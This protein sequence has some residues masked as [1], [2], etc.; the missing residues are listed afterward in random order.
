MI[1]GRYPYSSNPNRRRCSLTKRNA[2]ETTAIPIPPSASRLPS[3]RFRPMGR[4]RSAITTAP[5]KLSTKSG[6][7]SERQTLQ[8]SDRD[9]VARL[10]VGQALPVERHALVDVGDQRTQPLQ[11]QCAQ[12]LARQRLQLRLEDHARI[13]VER[14]TPALGRARGEAPLARGRI[15]GRG[16]G[17]QRSGSGCGRT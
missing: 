1:A 2:K 7:I 5:A 11:L 8:V 14:P 4:I 17:A 12:L 10:D 6:P 13:L 9:Y 15:S 3:T 16:P